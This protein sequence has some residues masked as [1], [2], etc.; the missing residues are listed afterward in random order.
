[1]PEVLCMDNY[2]LLSRAI[3]L[4]E[5]YNIFLHILFCGAIIII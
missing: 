1:M 5:I 4:N 3:K 2:D